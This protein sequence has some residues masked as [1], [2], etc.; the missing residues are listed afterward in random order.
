MSDASAKQQI[1]DKIKDSTNIL[2]T[3]SNNPSVDE[4]SAALGLSLLLNKI[5]KHA[6]AVFSGEIPPAI[7]FL[8]PE[9]TFENSVDSLRDFIIA[10]DKEKADHLRYKV[11]GDVVKIFITPYRTTIT[12]EDLDFSQGDYNVELVLALGVKNQKSLDKALAAHGQILNDATVVSVVA[13]S[14]KSDLGSIEWN[15]ARASSLSEMAVSLGDALKVDKGFIDEQIATAFLAGIVSATERFSNNR[16]SA[17]VMTIAAD[18]MKSGA[19]Q[20]LIA[21]KFEE[22]N[23]EEEAGEPEPVADRQPADSKKDRAPK[24]NDVPAEEAPPEQGAEQNTDGTTSL[25]EGESTKLERDESENSD[26]TPEAETSKS[27]SDDGTLHIPRE[28]EGTLDEVAQQKVEEDQAAAAAAAEAAVS[29]AQPVADAEQELADQLPPVVAPTA[30]L[31]PEDLRKDVEAASAEVEAA[32]EA[33][34]LQGAVSSE[35]WKNADEPVYG[36][37]LN[38]TAE[39]AAEDARRAAENDRNKMILSHG[40]SYIADQIPTYDAPINAASQKP[41][42]EVVVNPL[43]DAAPPTAQAAPIEPP[44]PT[45]ED[46]A[47]QGS[48]PDASGLPPLPDFS[49]LPPIPPP[50][51]G[52]PVDNSA[53]QDRLGDILPPADATPQPAAANN[54]P[55]QFRIPGQ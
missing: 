48:S 17:R 3:V 52:A 24:K 18:L 6:T 51:P 46:M 21:S 31:S 20:Q 37:T 25:S 10:L 39:V 33:P 27:E 1:A 9:K 30:D 35:V 54:D 32:A 47:P 38:A 19:N 12:S 2:V 42:E 11:E 36:G 26:E 55:G 14:E 44:A 34:P 28:K 45:L 8:D 5:K 41:E 22:A 13:G 40:G 49:T 53:P 50:P 15:D 16:T 4:L 43:H 23:E 7:T 29:A